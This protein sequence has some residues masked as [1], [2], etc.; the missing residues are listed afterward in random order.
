[1]RIYEAHTP[2]HPQSLSETLC[3]RCFTPVFGVLKRG[4]PHCFW[5]KM[6]SLNKKKK[7]YKYVKTNGI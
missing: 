5:I 2:A 3:R 1:M 4:S 7:V 6:I